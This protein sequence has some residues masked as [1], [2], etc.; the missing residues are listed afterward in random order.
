MAFNP[1][2]T[3]SPNKRMRTHYSSELRAAVGFVSVVLVVLGM[4]GCELPQN[5]SSTQ[6]L[7][8]Q[9][10]KEFDSRTISFTFNSVNGHAT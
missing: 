5:L 9:I 1:S 4:F 3:L 10:Q 8:T 2:R 6:E 7:T